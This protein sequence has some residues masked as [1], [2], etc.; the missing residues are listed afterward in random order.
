[1][2]VCVCTQALTDRN[3]PVSQRVVRGHLSPHI[4]AFFFLSLFWPVHYSNLQFLLQIPYKFHSADSLL[5]NKSVKTSTNIGSEQLRKH[6]TVLLCIT[7]MFL[8]FSQFYFSEQISSVTLSNWY[9]LR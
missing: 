2:C 3:S 8:S 5:E 6:I 9:V 7:F 1:M 4:V